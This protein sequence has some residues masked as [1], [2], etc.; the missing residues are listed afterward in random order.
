MTAAH[1]TLPLPTAVKVTNL[2]NNK[3]V[4]LR[5][6][7]RGPF[8]SN[9]IIDLSSKAADILELKRKGTG[10]VRVTVLKE[11]SIML[12]KLAQKGLFPEIKDLPK[13]ELPKINIP[14]VSNVKIEGNISK[15]LKNSINYDLK[16]LKEEYK[17]FINFASFNSFESAKNMK[18]KLSYVEK[19]NIHKVKRN[20]VIFYQVKAGPFSNVK[21]VDSLYKLLSNRGIQSAKIIIE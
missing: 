9:R 6:N 4:I 2:E 21:K 19:V 12:K 5:I 13:S 11:K 17:I 15:K 3:T 18:K 14:K 7:D 16:N 10:M 20:N 1:K 8:V